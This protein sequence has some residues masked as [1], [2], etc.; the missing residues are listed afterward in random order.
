M[1]RALAW[2]DP[3]PSL[4]VVTMPSPRLSSALERAEQ[5]LDRIDAALPPLVRRCAAEARLRGEIRSALADLD[6][7]I[8]EREDAR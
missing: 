7:L 4:G 5:A 3:H 8:A 6:R 1:H 2:Q